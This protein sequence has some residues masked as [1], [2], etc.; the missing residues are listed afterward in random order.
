MRTYSIL[1]GS[2]D[3]GSQGEI[4]PLWSRPASDLVLRRPS[5]LTEIV[6]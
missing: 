5:T 3:L 1:T 2:F 6:N 4:P